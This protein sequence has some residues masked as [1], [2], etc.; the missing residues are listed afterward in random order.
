MER[1]HYPYLWAAYKRGA[2]ADLP[3]FSE[4]MSA[5]LFSDVLTAEIVDLIQ[6]GGDTEVLIAKTKHGTIPVGIVTVQYSDRL[7]VPDAIWFA[8]ASA[9]NK[10][11]CTA[12][13]LVD[14]KAKSMVSI[15]AK[16]ENVTFYGSS[17]T[18]GFRSLPDSTVSV[19]NSIGLGSGTWDFRFL[20]TVA[21][22]NHNIYS[23]LFGTTAGANDQS[24][25][26]D[27][28]DLFV[29]IAAGNED[30][31]LEPTGHNALDTALDLSAT[32]T[33]D[34]DGQ[35]R[36]GPWDIGADEGNSTG[37]DL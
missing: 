20:G 34:I 36:S 5:A 3:I 22:F 4:D 1:I 9:R 33:T 16:P 26:A 11:E 23:A 35:T 29:S 27:L 28:E 15:A 25:P 10:L 19:R 14:L 12:N 8:D 30:L 21:D 32:F 17:G 31:H 7:A 18:D 24:P 13:F 6:A 2:F 37:P